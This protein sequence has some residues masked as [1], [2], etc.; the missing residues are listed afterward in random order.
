MAGGSRRDKHLCIRCG[1]CDLARLGASLRLCRGFRLCFFGSTQG[2]TSTAFAIGAHR[3]A[4][5][6][7]AGLFKA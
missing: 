6:V 4:V 3:H 7:G 1:Y 5:V 2:L